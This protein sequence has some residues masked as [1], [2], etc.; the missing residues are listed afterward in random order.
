M[1]R[2]KLVEQ[3]DKIYRDELEKKELQILSRRA[4]QKESQEMLFMH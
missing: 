3:N 2:R 4:S 1:N